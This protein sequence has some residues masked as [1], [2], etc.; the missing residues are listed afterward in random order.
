M[1]QL[2]IMERVLPAVGEVAI[3]LPAGSRVLDVYV[4]GREVILVLLVAAG[5][6]TA[7][8]RFVVAERGDQICS[9]DRHLASLYAA[10]RRLHIFERSNAP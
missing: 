2:R 5:A 8:H 6:P 7:V 4:N 9:S 3:E 10:G 1:N